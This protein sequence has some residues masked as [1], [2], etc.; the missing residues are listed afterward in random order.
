MKFRNVLTGVALVIATAAI[1]S[2]VVS[3]DAKPGAAQPP[4]SAEEQEF[5]NKW[6]AFASPNEHHK[7]FEQ[8][9]GT[10][11][12]SVKMWMEPDAPVSES[13]GTTTF[14]LGLDGRYLMDHSQ[15]ETP[16]GPFEGMGVT[17]YDNLKKKYV[18]GWIDNMGTGVM[19]GEG[20]YDAKAKTF[21]FTGESPD[22]NAGK[23][24]K[25]RATERWVNADT[26][27]MESYGPAK[28]GKEYRCME[29]TYTRAK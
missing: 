13:K 20:T 26:F 28:D 7:V 5:M 22:I 19:T 16:F 6:M 10:W 17:G 8:K 9:V 25:S 2:Q 12:T 18:Y 1:T 27:V 11:N 3:Q 4:M 15:G 14:E 29:I 23:Y 24:V 21:T